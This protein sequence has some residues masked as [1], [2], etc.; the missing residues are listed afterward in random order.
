MPKDYAEDRE[1]TAGVFETA[2]GWD[3]RDVA[4]FLESSQESERQRLEQAL[5]RIE[6]QLAERDAIHEA[7]VDDLEWTLE[8]Y[9]DRLHTLYSRNTG[10][11]DGSQE[12]LQDRIKEFSQELWNEHREHW[13]DRQAL[14]QERRE[15]R[16][17]LRELDDDALSDLL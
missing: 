10:K 9:T 17:E 12:R 2:A 1:E 5:D 4:A 14:E 11:H 7:V 15:V 13:R 6:H 3:D 8:Q 16:R